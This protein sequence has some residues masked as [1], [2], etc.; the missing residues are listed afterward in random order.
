MTSC[1]KS[2]RP[3]CLFDCASQYHPINHKHGGRSNYSRSA[4]VGQSSTLPVLFCPIPQVINWLLRSIAVAYTWPT[5]CC[6]FATNDD[7]SL[8][9]LRTL[10]ANLLILLD[11][12]QK[13]PVRF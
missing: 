7:S 3:Q 1:H 9:P 4:I 2:L 8:T 13:R 5:C 6:L 11:R 12:L 10:P